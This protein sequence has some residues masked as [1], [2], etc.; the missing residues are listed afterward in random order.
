MKLDKSI[1]FNAHHSPVG[2]FSTFTLGYRGPKGG[3]GCELAKPADQ[4]VFVGCESADTPG[5]FEALPFFGNSGNAESDFVVE[6]Q[7]D[8]LRK[9]PLHAMDEQTLSRN[10]SACVDRWNRN[11]F[12]FTVYSPTWQIPDP[13]NAGESELKRI[14]IPAV[15]AEITLDNRHCARKRRVF[16]GFQ[17]NHEHDHIREDWQL[18]DEQVAALCV[19]RQYGVA[20][21]YPGAKTGIHFAMQTLLAEPDRDRFHFG[22]GT[23]GMLDW[24]VPAGEI[25][26]VPL[27]L[28]FHRSGI[29]TTGIESR[30]Y[31]NRFF[32]NLESVLC[33]GLEHF[34]TYKTAAHELDRLWDRPGL[35]DSQRFHIAH[36]IRS[37]Y[38][39]TQLLERDG[40]PM[41]VVNEGE[42]RMINTLDLTVDQLFFEMRQNPWTTRNVLDHFLEFYSYDDQVFEPGKPN[43]MHPGGMSFCH[44]MGVCNSFMRFGHS[45]Y[46]V[47]GLK[48]CF[49]YMTHEE[50]VN[51][52]CCALVYVEQAGDAD[53]ARK[54][55][56]I[57]ESLFESL[58]HR[59]HYDPT[60]RDGIMAMDSS[61]TLGGSEITTYD[62]L[63]PSLGQSRGNLYLG[64]KTWSVY[65][66]LE[67]LFENMKRPGLAA[68]CR[69][70][71]LRAMK[72]IM[73][74]VREDGILPASIE[75]DSKAT[76]IPVVEGLVFLEFTG[77]GDVLD[78]ESP[79]RSLIEGMRRHLIAVLK[80]G[81]CLFPDG[82]WRLTTGNTN[83][84][85]SKIYLCQYIARRLLGLRLDSTGETADIAHEM[86]LKSP[87]NAYW[88]WGDQFYAGIVRGSR[89]YPRG[90]TSILWLME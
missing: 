32:P 14:L 25:V 87:E 18:M 13:E 21:Q 61:R 65:L 84:W 9:A 28:A 71:A 8:S 1:C 67:R 45:C 4:H 66:G 81:S 85:L 54:N 49:S 24:V 74:A 35:N 30:Y 70:Q 75:P 47:S 48:G 68:N 31:Y 73:A 39:S 6:E 36:S 62:S 88:A 23:T 16:F 77:R 43:V 20:T 41:W 40:K 19:G 15:F 7:G 50:L 78:P 5:A 29:V 90:V 79:Y 89:Y 58:L 44:D 27:V 86:W 42:Y 83:S 51:W 17:P 63:D 59:D 38:G 26:T 76:I 22:N 46:E 37:Y 11:D 12:T 69:D 57:F 3:F 55:L 60:R 2:A 10:F 33:Y 64:V 82:S 52:L 34:E 53:W 56:Q 72:T 80:P